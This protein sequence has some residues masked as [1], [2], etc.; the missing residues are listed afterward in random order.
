MDINSTFTRHHAD[1]LMRIDF[2]ELIPQD[3]I[4]EIFSYLNRKELTGC[5]K[6]S[7]QWQQL[8]STQ[9][10][11]DALPKGF[12]KT[13]WA[14]YFGD[15]GVVPSLPKE[16]NDILKSPC[17]FWPGKKVQE[18]HFLILIPEMIDNQLLS[19]EHLGEHVKSPKKGHK[20]QFSGG[21][22]L[23]NIAHGYGQQAPTQAH[24]VL[25]TK[26]V[27]PQSRKKSYEEQQDLLTVVHEKTG[28]K[29]EIPHV[30]EACICIFVYHITSGKFL[31]GSKDSSSDSNLLLSTYTRCQTQIDGDQIEVG[32]FSQSGLLIH[33]FMNNFEYIGIAAIR[34]L[35]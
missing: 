21:Q 2:I 14:E 6:V 23:G 22:L 10:L 31:F 35:T 5:L 13:Q 11:W 17:P 29:Y 15:I 19:L 20:T 30:L 24:W 33:P 12:D 16:I 3:I 28:I 25:M 9:K 7:K 32:G 27:I 26:D 4:L 1:S 18:T 8:A 34:H